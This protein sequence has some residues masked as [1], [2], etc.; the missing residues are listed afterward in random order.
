M[1]AWWGAAW[2]V[3]V[4]ACGGAGGDWAASETSARAGVSVAGGEAYDVVTTASA[5]SDGYDQAPPS[6]PQE[7][8]VYAQ[9][10]PVPG[11]A[12]AGAPTGDAGAGPSGTP[13]PGAHATDAIDHRTPLLI[14]T[15]ELLL[16]VHLVEEKQDAAIAIVE[17]LGGF[18]AQRTDNH[19]V[20]R[21]PAP[22]FQAAVDAIEEVGDVLSRQVQAQDVSEEFRDLSIRVRNLE[23]MRSRLEQLLQR[24]EDVEEAIQVEQQLERITVELERLKGRLRFL[25]DRLAYSTITIRFRALT[26]QN[27]EPRFELP[28]PWLRELGLP[29]LMRL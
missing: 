17:E 11:A 14:Y 6:A 5:E 21:V 9:N 2:V 19:V 28:F 15:A 16:A 3:G 18:L 24:A 27:V 26:T 12:P 4:V 8:A 20:L 13:S 1:R 23:A 29:N 25:E 22:K 7:P 10:E